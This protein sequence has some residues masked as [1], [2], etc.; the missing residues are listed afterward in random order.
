MAKRAALMSQ[1]ATTILLLGG[2]D[3]SDA[4]SR[5]PPG[6][7]IAG[8]NYEGA[9]RGYRSMD[10]RERFDGH[11]K[12]SEAS[13]AVQK[14]KQGTVALVAGQIVTGA[15]SGASG[16][17]VVNQILVSGAYGGG[18]AAGNLVLYNVTGVFQN[19]EAIQVGGVTKAHADGTQT[20]RGAS[21]DDDDAS[22]LHAATEARRA[23]I[24]AVP[25]SG[26][27]RG[28]WIFKGV[29]YAFRDN[30]GATAS[31]MWHTTATGWAAVPLGRTI[32]YT[33]GTSFLLANSPGLGATSGATAKIVSVQVVTGSLAAGTATGFLTLAGQAGVFVAENVTIAANVAAHVAGNSTAVALLPGGKNRFVSH[34]FFGASNL[35][36]M[37]WCDGVNNAYQFNGDFSAAGSAICAI[38]TGMV[39]DAPIYIEVHKNQLF[40]GF[41]GGSLQ[42]CAP[43]SP[44]QWSA[45]LGADEIGIG[46]DITGLISAVSGTLLILGANSIHVLYGN[47]VDDWQ[48]TTLSD[49]SGGY[50]DT[51][52]NMTEPFYVD[53]WGIRRMSATQAY[54]NFNFAAVS[55]QF[56]SLF[57]QKKKA[58]LKPVGSVRVRGKSSYRVFY[59]DGSGI[60]V[61][62]GRSRVSALSGSLTS[63]PEGYE[64]NIGFAPQCLCSYE[65]L[66][67]AEGVNSEVVLAGDANGMVFQLDAGTSMDGA[68]WA[69]F[70]RLSYFN[71]K[72][73]AV[74]KSWKKATV[75][76]DTDAMA[77]LGLVAEFDY[78]NEFTAPAIEQAFEVFGGGGAFDEANWDEVYWSSSINGRAEAYLD[79]LAPSCSLVIF[80][81]ATT[82]KPHTLQSVTFNYAMRGLVK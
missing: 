9:P 62:L 53:A 32:A 36:C 39:V 7:I 12:P 58:K 21:N 51:V 48:L 64:F 55:D 65:D 72:S 19:N 52:Q 13:Y 15:T 24:A 54:G 68:A 56:Q 10:G 59:S 73:P 3:L 6:R 40:L 74:N 27:V 41:R 61:Y 16:I 35:K 28:V 25:G 1:S 47:S 18:T 80:F 33:A 46:E 37:Y 66:T 71:I 44:F 69:G 75:E 78:G 49:D 76:L 60:N 2:L 70:C 77:E 34:N 23:V 50:D 22:W 38:R 17:L 11:P 20:D 26:P 45:V 8:L 42:N 63:S 4:P 31:I 29:G 5:L 14:F 81:N 82:Q 67:G 79:G 57:D 43:G 30:A